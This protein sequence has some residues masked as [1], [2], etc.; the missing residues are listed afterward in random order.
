[1]HIY[2]MSMINLFVLISVLFLIFII[3]FF[4]RSH[5]KPLVQRYYI[6][7]YVAAVLLLVILPLRLLCKTTGIHLLYVPVTAFSSCFML[8]FV[9]VCKG[10]TNP[11]LKGCIKITKYLVTVL[12]LSIFLSP[13]AILSWDSVFLLEKFGVKSFVY[14][15][16]KEHIIQWH[17]PASSFSSFGAPGGFFYTQEQRLGAAAVGNRRPSEL[18]TPRTFNNSS[19]SNVDMLHILEK[20]KIKHGLTNETADM[21]FQQHKKHIN[22]HIDWRGVEMKREWR[23]EAEIEALRNNNNNN[24]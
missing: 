13:L 7:L 3:C 16:L 5:L 9:S 12:F 14:F 22:I 20:L 6:Y 11:S 4:F 8:I 18:F 15:M 24:N 19:P 23:T 10:K 2:L 17:S 21:I 1:M